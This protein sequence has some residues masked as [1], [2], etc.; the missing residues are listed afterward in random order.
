MPLSYSLISL[1]NSP[2]PM[3][4]YYNTWA[5]YLPNKVNAIGDHG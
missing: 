3:L 2:E 5:I 1:I 4:N